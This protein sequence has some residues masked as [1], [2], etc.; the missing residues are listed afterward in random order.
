MEITMREA[1]A[2]G[3]ALAIADGMKAAEYARELDAMTEQR[4]ALQKKCTALMDENALK[5]DEIR[6]LRQENRNY[7]FSRS[8][9]YQ[10]SLSEQGRT[11]SYDALHNLA[12]MALGS[13]ITFAI[14]FTIIWI[15][16][17]VT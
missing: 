11:V 4:D 14:C 17:V 8:R 2:E 13:V 3:V 5:E 9:A 7:R 1:G 6:Q 16:G 10:T 12:W 15:V